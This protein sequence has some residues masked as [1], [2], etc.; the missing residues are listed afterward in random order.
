MSWR[1]VAALV[2]AA[3]VVA[4]LVGLA[5]GVFASEPEPPRIVVRSGAQEQY[6]S[7]NNNHW[8]PFVVPARCTGFNR[9]AP[10]YPPEPLRVEPGSEMV[11]EIETRSIP[12]RFSVPDYGRSP[13]VAKLG[14]DVAPATRAEVAAPTEPGE[15]EITAGA[16]FFLQGHVDRGFYLVVEPAQ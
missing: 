8:C 11:F 4:L 15:Y 9:D 6:G 13:T 3:V 2:G 7:L 16:D 1:R 10:V 14:E 5:V 12:T